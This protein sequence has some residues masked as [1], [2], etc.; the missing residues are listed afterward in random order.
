MVCK[1]KSVSFSYFQ[2]TDPSIKKLSVLRFKCVLFVNKWVKLNGSRI[3]YNEILI[4]VTHIFLFREQEYRKYKIIPL[5][6]LFIVYLFCSFYSPS[7]N[8][9]MTTILNVFG[10]CIVF[11]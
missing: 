3:I 5:C 6:L 7:H 10:Y 8:H 11:K 2:T 1:E 4:F 9:K